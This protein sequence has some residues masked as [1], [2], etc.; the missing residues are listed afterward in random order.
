[1]AVRVDFAAGAVWFAAAMPEPPE[2]QRVFVGGD[3]IMV[4]FSHE[5]MRDRGFGDSALLR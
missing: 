5:K 3:E 1:M 4:V 2:S